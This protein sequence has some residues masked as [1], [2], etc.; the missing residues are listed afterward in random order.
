MKMHCWKQTMV[1]K[2]V[3]QID[4]DDILLEC[5]VTQNMSRDEL[6]NTN[7]RLMTMITNYKNK[8]SPYYSNKTWDK[9]KKVSNEYELIFTTPN[10]KTNV[11]SYNPVSR[12]FFKMWE[13]LNDFENEIV[14]NDPNTHVKCLFLAEG[15][16]GFLEAVMKYRNTKNDHY[17]GMTLKP[18]H[19]SVPEWKLK[20]FD[21]SYIST[22]YGADNTGNLYNLENTHYL[23]NSLGKNCMDLVTADGGFDFSSDFN[24][25][26]DLSTKLVYC[27]TFCAFHMLK[28][29]GTYILKIY[30]IF[31]EH[32]LQMLNILKESFQ[33]IHIIKPLTSRPANSEKYIVCCGFNMF[34]GHDFISVIEHT[35]NTQINQVPK[36]VSTSMDLDL[37]LYQKIVMYNIYYTSRQI[38]YIQKTINYIDEFDA[39]TSSERYM[40]QDD[41]VLLNQKKCKK[42]CTKY[43]IPYNK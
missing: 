4:C 14:S 17:Y 37:S 1:K 32:T 41:L 23:A 27:E 25:Q 2:F 29:K 36:K 21:M 40:R 9:Y 31:H 20:K 38:Y 30:D 26:E 5:N 7:R 43:N 15:P 3:M 16:G 39:L 34:K 8:I 19:R 11:S 6:E 42:W 13:I 12:S 22:L 10:A 35:L 28:D 33:K 24:N 18:D